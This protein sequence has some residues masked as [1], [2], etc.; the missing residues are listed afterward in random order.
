[1]KK[2]FNNTRICQIVYDWKHDPIEIPPNCVF[3]SRNVGQFKV[4]PNISKYLESAKRLLAIRRFALGDVLMLLC[5]LRELKSY[6]KIDHITLATSGMLAAHPV[7]NQLNFSADLIVPISGVS[8]LSYDA[9]C[10]L[11]GWLELDHMSDE[12]S[13][14]HR[15]DLYREFFGLPT[16]RSPDWSGFETRVS[17][18]YFVFC[19][20][21]RR[22]YNSLSPRLAEEIKTALS[23]HKKV[24]TISDENRVE[25][26]KLVDIIAGASVLVTVDSGPLWIAHYTATPVVF[27]SGPTKPEQ[28][29]SYHPLY[30]DGVE[31]VQLAERVGCSSCFERAANCNFSAA[32]MK[33]DREAKA[34]ASEVVRKVGK[35]RWKR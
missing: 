7:I 1:V 11:D 4:C 13:S 21:G 18:E 8:K 34:I 35:V 14:K 17:A 15:V 12:F 3:P 6:Y 22:I 25:D 28:R 27:L 16:G 33:N 24:V 29:V 19:P 30:P 23:R 5:V 10:H 9:A 2:V 20:A 31:T 26:D 32:C